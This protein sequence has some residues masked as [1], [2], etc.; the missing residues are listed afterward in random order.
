MVIQIFSKIDIFTSMQSS[1]P[2]LMLSVTEQ[3]IIW[4]Q[5]QLAGTFL[6]SPDSWHKAYVCIHV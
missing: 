1:L 6:V 5:E 2:L 4:S 3:I